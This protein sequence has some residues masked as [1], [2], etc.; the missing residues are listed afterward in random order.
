[1][2]SGPRPSKTFWTC[3][4]VGRSSLIFSRTQRTRR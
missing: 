1:M 2:P 4:Q 3:S